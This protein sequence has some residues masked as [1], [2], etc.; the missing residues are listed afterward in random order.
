MKTQAELEIFY[1]ATC[2]FCVRRAAWIRKRDSADA[3]RLTDLNTNEDMLA[4]Y[5]ANIEEAY[6]EIH[7][8]DKYGNLI[9]GWDVIT[10]ALE[11]LKYYRTLWIFEWPYVH[12]VAPCIY[13]FVN[14]HKTELSRF[15]V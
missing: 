11:V 14:K 6:K 2:A 12:K 1:D 10:S 7:A 9:R 13:K 8:V 5:G 4:L 15:G 3:I